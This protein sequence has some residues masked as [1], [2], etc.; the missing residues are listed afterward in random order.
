MGSYYPIKDG[1]NWTTPNMGLYVKV[2]KGAIDALISPIMKKMM[3]CLRIITQ[4]ARFMG[5]NMGSIWGPKDPGGP[6]IGPMNFAIWELLRH[7]SEPVKSWFGYWLIQVHRLTGGGNQD[8]G[9]SWHH[10]ILPMVRW[11]KLCITSSLFKRTTPLV[12]IPR[13]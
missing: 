6:H 7:A 5:A 11:W 1:A 4:I 3:V 9:R 13:I 10:T 12:W 8:N 2:S